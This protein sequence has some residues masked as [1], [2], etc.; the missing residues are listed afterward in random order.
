MRRRRDGREA[1]D[2]VL[3]GARIPAGLHKLAKIYSARQ[4]IMMRDLL[5]RALTEFLDREERQA[6][7]KRTKP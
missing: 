3:F 1:T 5:E 7:A 6:G 4:G 2:R